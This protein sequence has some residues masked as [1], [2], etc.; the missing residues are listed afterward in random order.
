MSFILTDDLSKNKVASQSTT[1][2]ATS[3]DA[4]KYVA[5][6]AV[7]R[8]LTTC[9]RAEPIGENSDYYQVW[10]KVD[11]GAV[12]N[13]YSV[14]ILFKNYEGNERRQ[15]G[16]FAGFSVYVSMNGSR[17]ASSLCY[18]DGPVLPHLNFTTHCFTYG[19]YVIFFNERNSELKYPDEYQLTSVYTELCEVIVL[20]CTAGW[21][22]LDCKQECSGNCKDNTVCNHVTG[23]CDGGCAAGRRGTL[24]DKACREGYYGPNCSRTCP[25]NCKACKATDGTCS[26]YAGW[27]GPN[28]SIGCVWSYGEDCQYP[29]SK[30][31]VNQTCDRFNGS[32][33]SVCD[34]GFH[35]QKCDQ[36]YAATFS[37]LS[38]LSSGILGASVSAGVFITS[39]IVI[40]IVW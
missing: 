7:D 33:L 27:M 11:L 22:G 40:L 13:I 12:Y 19:R 9:M 20:E 36:E 2:A 38:T 1:Y 24:C 37:V 25:S 3:S 31:C 10:W 14:N 34:S 4:F 18:K 30:H 16:R 29:C 26:C 21:Y 8:D 6:N 35:G 17:D 5:G 15:R 28:C 39:G 23:Q 32:C